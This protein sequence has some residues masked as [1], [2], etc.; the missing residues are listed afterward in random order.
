MVISTESVA[1]IF[2]RPES[3][4]RRKLVRKLLSCLSVSIT[5][6]STIMVIIGNGVNFGL[7]VFP[8]WPDR[9]SLENT[10]AVLTLLFSVFL[11]CR[12]CRHRVGPEQWTGW[13]TGRACFGLCNKLIRIVTCRPVVQTINCSSCYNIA[14]PALTL[15]WKQWFTGLKFNER[16]LFCLLKSRQIQFYQETPYWW[17]A[18]SHGPLVTSQKSLVTSDWTPATRH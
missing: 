11:F 12:C 13:Q 9:A 3:G 8:S 14:L 1:E 16:L 15:G 4:L 10:R 17:L 6:I 18:A 7:N 5:H 2:C